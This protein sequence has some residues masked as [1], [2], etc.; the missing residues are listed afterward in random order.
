M[1]EPTCPLCSEP[2]GAPQTRY[3]PFCSDLCKAQ[4]MYHWI[5]GSYEAQLYGDEVAG[6]DDGF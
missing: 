6:E 5:D 2:A 1:T 4:D 3:F